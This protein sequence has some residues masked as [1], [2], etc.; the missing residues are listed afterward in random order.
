MKKGGQN[1]RRLMLREDRAVKHWK[2]A[3]SILRLPNVNY[4]SGGL[5]GTKIRAARPRNGCISQAQWRI[6]ARSGGT[7]NDYFHVGNRRS[8]KK[9]GK[10]EPM[11]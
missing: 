9:I 6:L 5:S 10:D 8:L 11:Q 4:K 2:H 1:E 3:L 7:M